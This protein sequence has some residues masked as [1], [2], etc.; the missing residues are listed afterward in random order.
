[1]LTIFGGRVEDLRTVLLE[2]RLPDG[3]QSRVRSPFGLTFGAFNITVFK[4]A[5]GVKEVPPKVK[6]NTDT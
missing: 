6:G 5:S 1:M 2:E 4:V 3:W